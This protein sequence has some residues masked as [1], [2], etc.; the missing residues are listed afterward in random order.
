[1]WQITWNF[2]P[3]EEIWSETEFSWVIIFSISEDRLSDL[4]RWNFSSYSHFVSQFTINTFL[5]A[6]A[7]KKELNDAPRGETNRGKHCN[8]ALAV[9][10]ICTSES[11][12]A[13]TRSQPTRMR[14]SAW[15]DEAFRT[16][17][18]HILYFNEHIFVEQIFEILCAQTAITVMNCKLLW[19]AIFRPAC[20]FCLLLT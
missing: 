4:L 7:E 3:P 8:D 15:R 20:W 13:T 2:H 17:Y 5:L 14:C 19:F 9:D 11:C 6:L 16:Q 12:G 1:M 18:E 10:E